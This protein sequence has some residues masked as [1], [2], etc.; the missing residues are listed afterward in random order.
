LFF[1]FEEPF[2]K[3]LTIG[4]AAPDFSSGLKRPKHCQDPIF[5]F[6]F[7]FIYLAGNLPN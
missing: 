5:E 6:K 1:G 7:S 3:A 4:A 2:A